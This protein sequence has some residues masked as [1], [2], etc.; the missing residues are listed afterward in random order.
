MNIV[1]NKVQPIIRKAAQNINKQV[2]VKDTK[3]VAQQ[4]VDNYTRLR[5][6]LDDM[7]K[8]FEQKFPDAN[9]EINAIR[10]FKDS[11]QKS[12]DTA[13]ELVRAA[14]A[15]IG[16]FV[17]TPKFAK[18][19]YDAS[20]IMEIC[21]DTDNADLLLQMVNGGFVKMSFDAGAAVLF[22]DS[23]PELKAIVQD[24]W[25]DRKPLTPSVTT[26]KL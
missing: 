12:I 4:A 22:F 21:S 13:K 18:A 25:E 17:Y 23:N 10:D 14:G 9:V 1:P 3:A 16:E 2:D 5:S 11:V 20:K 24:A 7:E 26:P 19:G 15:T 6:E 8:D